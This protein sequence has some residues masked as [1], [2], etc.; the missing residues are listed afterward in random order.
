MRVDTSEE[1]EPQTGSTEWAEVRVVRSRLRPDAMVTQPF[2]I[3]PARALQALNDAGCAVPQMLVP[4]TNGV[5]S[6]RMDGMRLDQLAGDLPRDQKMAITDAVARFLASTRKADVSAKGLERV[7]RA[8]PSALAPAPRFV[9]EHLQWQDP[10]A[11]PEN[12]RADFLE[13]LRW[14]SALHGRH[15]GHVDALLHDVLGLPA[16]QMALEDGPLGYIAA[17]A[18]QIRS[19]RSTSLVAR[20]ISDDNLVV[21]RDQY[22]KNY[23]DVPLVALGLSQYAIGDPLSG[24]SA[25]VRGCRH[26]DR[27]RLVKT[28]AEDTNNKHGTTSEIQ[29]E[30]DVLLAADAA[31]GAISGAVRVALHGPRALPSRD[32]FVEDLRVLASRFEREVDIEAVDNWLSDRALAQEPIEVMTL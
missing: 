3:H 7:D 32:R 24:L 11:A 18:E 16:W 22:V 2:G 14:T 15:R 12:A 29:R 25:A 31:M 26:V 21:S 9:A 23:N 5:I 19:S 30:L 6:R 8:V 10:E 28:F 27:N 20:G 4:T 13:R 17:G 1:W